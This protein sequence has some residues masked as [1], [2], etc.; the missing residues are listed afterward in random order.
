[1]AIQIY[2]DRKERN[3]MIEYV[4][5]EKIADTLK[6][7]EIGSYAAGWN[8]SIRNAL[9]KKNITRAVPEEAFKV[10]KKLLESWKNEA[11]Y[12]KEL[13]IADHEAAT[14][15]IKRSE[16]NA[17]ELALNV[18]QMLEKYGEESEEEAEEMACAE[19]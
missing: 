9:K 8:D 6:T 1:M 18:L 17:F 10:V 11:K 16:E 4:S 14:A 7:G 13:A 12:K 15:E 5:V 2:S 3:A 19:N